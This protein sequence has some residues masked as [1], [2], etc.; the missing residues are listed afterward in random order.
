M[1]FLRRSRHV[2]NQA[3]C[4]Q[5]YSLPCVVCCPAAC[6][7]IPPWSMTGTVAGVPGGRA[8]TLDAVFAADASSG[9]LAT[10]MLHFLN[11]RQVAQLFGPLSTHYHYTGRCHSL[12]HSLTGPLTV[13]SVAV[14]VT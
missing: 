8:P 12:A 10:L 14:C 3:A 9:S 11:Q 7:S 4:Y 1:L 5:H 2:S 13:V 6:L